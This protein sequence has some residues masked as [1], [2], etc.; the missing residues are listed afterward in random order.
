MKKLFKI[1]LFTVVMSLIS[2]PAHSVDWKAVGDAAKAIYAV[3]LEVYKALP[4]AAYALTVVAQ[5][6]SV[7]YTQTNSCEDA[8]VKALKLLSEQ[9]VREVTI[10]SEHSTVNYSCWGRTYTQSDIDYLRDKTR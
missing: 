5:D 8:L 6:G 10:V 7:S 9:G 2:L 4:D 1:T 3:G